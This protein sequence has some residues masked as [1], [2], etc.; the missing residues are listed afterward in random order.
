M[1]VEQTI[2]RLGRQSA[3]ELADR[4]AYAIFGAPGNRAV[5][6]DNNGEVTVEGVRSVIPDELVG[7]YT[8]DTLLL[9]LSRR[10]YSDLRAAIDERGIRPRP[11]A[12]KRVYAGRRPKQEAA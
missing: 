6:I 2:G 11:N 4:A 5:C 9:T 12:R 8:P 7:V 1:S 3:S 10:I